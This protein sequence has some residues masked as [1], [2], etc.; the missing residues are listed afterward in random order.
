MRKWFVYMENGAWWAAKIDALHWFSSQR[1][2]FD[3]AFT[4]ATREL[5]D[6]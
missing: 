3:F 4:E 1:D 2:A 5:S 6:R